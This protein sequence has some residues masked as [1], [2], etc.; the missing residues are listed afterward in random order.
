M[1]QYLLVAG[2]TQKVVDGLVR[3][4]MLTAGTEWS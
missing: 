2:W 3:E 1:L 4:G